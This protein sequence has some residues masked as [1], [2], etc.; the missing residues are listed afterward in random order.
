VT[1]EAHSQSAKDSEHSV[2][3]AQTSSGAR[4]NERQSEPAAAAE[5]TPGDDQARSHEPHVNV[6]A[7]S[8]EGAIT[9]GRLE[10]AA[11]NAAARGVEEAQAAAQNRAEPLTA[12]NPPAREERQLDFAEADRYAAS[13]RPSWADA[14]PPVVQPVHA[15]GASDGVARV[16]RHNTRIDLNPPLR[17]RRGSAYAILGASLLGV[18]G[19]LYLGISSSTLDHGRHPRAHEL[20]P[21]KSAPV[22][23]APVEPE[24]TVHAAQ[25]PAE[26]NPQ[27]ALPSE[28]ALAAGEPPN[29]AA[30]APVALAAETQAQEGTANTEAPAQLAAA[31]S[32]VA[33]LEP[34]AQPEPLAAAAHAVEPA[35]QPAQPTAAQPGNAT[36]ASAT[37]EAN[38]AAPNAAPQAIAAAPNAALQANAGPHTAQLQAADPPQ[39]AAAPR[40]NAAAH[41][42]Q[43]QAAAAPRATQAPAPAPAPQPAAP[44]LATSEVPELKDLQPSAAAPAPAG[45][46]GRG[47]V[48]LDLG[49]YP[50][51]T[52]LHVDGVLVGNPYRMRVPKSSKHRIDAAAPGFEPETHVVRMEAD[53]QLMISLKREPPRDVKADPYS[54]ATRR[55]PAGVAAPKRDRGAGFVAENPY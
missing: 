39:A 50:P 51:N 3:E 23:A 21:A 12:A 27:P 32:T 13:I 55:T 16:I 18:A 22:N 46:A 26:A 34:Q 33:Q 14:E 29:A 30:P 9:P 41:A 44:K 4:A 54:E 35:V 15:I 5:A 11:L 25:A 8:D 31:P 6:A 7:H 42:T 10:A 1:T 28:P 40:A 24:T 19:L 48:L 37:A 43:L 17:K 49:A 52:H 47:K 20:K 45:A 53:V 38:A 2:D 36:Q